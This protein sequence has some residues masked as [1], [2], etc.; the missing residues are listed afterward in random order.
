MHTYYLFDHKPMVRVIVNCIYTPIG[1]R[2]DLG[3]THVKRL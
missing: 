3:E 2:E 1:K